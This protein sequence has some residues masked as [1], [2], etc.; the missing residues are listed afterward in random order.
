MRINIHQLRSGA[1]AASLL[2]LSAC[3]N[4]APE[5]VRPDAPV[6]AGWQ[7][8]VQGN[9]PADAAAAPETAW[10]SVIVDAKLRQVIALAL[11]NNRDLRVALANLEKAQATYR[12][13]RS[14]LFPAINATGSM[15]RER[16]PATAATSGQESISSMYKAQ[17]G[18]SSYELDL[19]G[20]VRNLNE[21]ALQS[22]LALGETQRSV[23]L[24]LVA[25]VATAWL[26][27]NADQQQLALANA[28]LATRE[29]SLDLLQQ[30]HAL[31]AESGPGLSA[32]R[33]SR[34]A[35]RASVAS[36]ASVV[37]KDRH[38]LDLLVGATVPEAMLPAAAAAGEGTDAALLLSVPEG[39]S[40]SLLLRRPDVLS[41]E[42]KLIAD[43]AD[44]GA[45]R[46]AFFPRIALT[47]A[48]GSSSRSLGDLFSAGSGAWSFAPSISLPIFNAGANQASL[49]SAKAQQ[50]ADLATYEKAIQTAFSEV[51]DALSVRTHVGEQIDAQREQ[52]KA[53][54]QNLGYAEELRRA[55]S[56]SALDVMD[57]QR[58][59]FT[60][61]QTL[62][63]LQLAEQSNRVTLFKALGGGEAGA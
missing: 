7:A 8:K 47:A 59:L 53:L 39:L 13:Q 30:A 24:S 26:T 54:Q 32:A 37:E 36:Y 57:A 9:A 15:T 31:G 20:R 14:N 1:F 51:A 5:Y 4:L 11:D 44:I 2:T 6:P 49:D 27:L 23:R 48:G 12:I 60:A 61:Q 21:A 22:Y 41:A 34:E 52:V 42:H 56:G 46:A 19:F 58:S 25:S 50:R 38:A 3:M 17:L 43:S 29:H 63:T 16:T 45:A 40:S 55:G 62:I 33:A 35:A 18:F 28:T 10:Q